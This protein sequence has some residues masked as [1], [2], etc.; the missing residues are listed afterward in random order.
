MQRLLETERLILRSSSMDD[1]EKCLEMDMDPEVTKYI[2]GIWDGSEAHLS[3]LKKNILGTY[4]EGLGY[5]SVFPKKTPFQFLGWILLVPYEAEAPEIEIGWRLKRS[6]WGKG[7]ATEAAQAVTAHA[8]RTVGLEQIYAFVDYGNDRSV[9]VAQK[10][11][12]KAFSD[13]IYDG[14]PCTAYRLT[15]Q[16]YLQNKI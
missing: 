11:G 15:R 12:F 2:P 16:E 1:L 3:F 4:K 9:K 14:V 7:Y 8:F 10:L 5:W 6:A 13:F